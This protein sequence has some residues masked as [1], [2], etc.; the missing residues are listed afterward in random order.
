MTSTVSTNLQEQFGS[1]TRANLR[2]ILLPFTTPFSSDGSLDLTAL[3]SN[4][5]DWNTK[6]ISGYVALGSTGEKAH[7]DEREYLQV[8]ETSRSEVPSDLLFIVGVAQNSTLKAISEIRVAASSG[9]D[10]VLVLTPHYYRPA[11]TQQ[12][13]VNH[14]RAVADASPVPVILYSMPALTGVKIAPDTVATLNQHENII[15]IKDSSN[16]LEEF[17]STVKLCSPEFAVITGNGTVLY[18]ALLAGAR[19]A[20]LAVGCVV[21]EL[22]VEI[23]TAA[24]NDEHDRAITLQQ[25]LTPL[26]SAVTTKYGIGGLKNALDMN[27]Y[28]GGVVRAPLRMPDARAREEIAQLLNE[29]EAA[30]KIAHVR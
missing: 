12:V 13:L 17:T 23:L 14:Y 24:Q 8:V 28:K 3:Q 25:T 30:L 1:R 16:D 21:P 22:C 27:G 11:M 4:I 26:A 20:I 18:D 19:A 15:G 29:A 10:A 7:L 9:A 2:G 6:G 5:K